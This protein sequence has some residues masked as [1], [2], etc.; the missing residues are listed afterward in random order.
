MAGFGHQFPNNNFADKFIEILLEI[1]KLKDK[2]NDKIKDM[3]EIGNT[4]LN[5]EDTQAKTNKICSS[6][7]FL[8]E[9]SDQLI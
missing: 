5:L 9:K 1:N 3:D 4:Y 8:L 7:H 2:N 6:K